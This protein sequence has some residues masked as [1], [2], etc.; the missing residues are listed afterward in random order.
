MGSKVRLWRWRHNSLKRRSDV[1]EA[2]VALAVGAAM[3]VGAPAAG[4]ATAWGVNDFWQQQRQDRQRTSAVLTENAPSAAV[5]A[6]G[7]KVS[8][9]VRWTTP[10]G[11][12]RTGKAKVEAGLKAGARITV[13]T[14]DQGALTTEPPSSVEVQSEAGLAGAAAAGGVCVL[15]WAGHRVARSRLDRRRGEEWDHAWA[16]VGPQWTRRRT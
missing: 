9:A 7:G 3:M 8:A 14:D 11:T 6:S 12:T 15:L 10:D 2:W 13:W 1:T 4:A 16:E 5:Y